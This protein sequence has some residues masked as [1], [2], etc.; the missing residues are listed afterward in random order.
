MEPGLA[1]NALAEFV[2]ALFQ[3]YIVPSYPLKIQTEINIYIVINHLLLKHQ[4]WLHYS[5]VCI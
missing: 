5:N 3:Y 1:V 4:I 2:F